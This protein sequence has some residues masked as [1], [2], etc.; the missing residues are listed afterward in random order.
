V[1]HSGR[2]LEVILEHR[3]AAQPGDTRALA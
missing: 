1:L 2:L 3:G